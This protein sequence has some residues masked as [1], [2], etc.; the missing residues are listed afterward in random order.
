MP[1][2]HPGQAEKSRLR[3]KNRGGRPLSKIATAVGL[4]LEVLH[5]RAEDLE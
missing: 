4:P 5:E 2:F 1:A 3:D